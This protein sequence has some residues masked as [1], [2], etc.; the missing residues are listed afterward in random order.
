MV[1]PAGS[2]A[3]GHWPDSALQ[4]RNVGSLH[5]RHHDVQRR[6]P[7]CPAQNRNAIPHLRNCVRSPGSGNIR[8]EFCQRKRNC[9]QHF[10]QRRCCLRILLCP[11]L[12]LSGQLRSGCPEDSELYLQLQQLC[13][14]HC[15]DRRRNQ[16]LRLQWSSVRVQLHEW[17]WRR[18]PQIR[19]HALYLPDWHHL[20]VYC[21][22]SDEDDSFC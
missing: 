4:R 9:R 2:K 14:H 16:C 20:R 13:T 21:L 12:Q 5:Q 17:Q 19:Q 22:Q 1:F 8:P 11:E 15:A 6:Q 10:L 7:Q 3:K 18:V